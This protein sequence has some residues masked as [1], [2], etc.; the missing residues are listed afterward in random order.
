MTIEDAIQ[1]A[2]TPIIQ[3]LRREAECVEQVKGGL[4]AAGYAIV[5]I[6]LTEAMRERMAKIGDGPLRT[7][8]EVWSE[9]L[10]A[11]LVMPATT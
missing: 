7:Y 11:A 4:L 2:I 9:M 5:P 3:D 6:A 10:D 8:E 1:I